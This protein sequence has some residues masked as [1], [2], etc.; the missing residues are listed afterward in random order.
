MFPEES[1]AMP[2]GPMDAYFAGISVIV[3]DKS[4]VP[5][6]VII[7]LAGKHPDPSKLK[8]P[9]VQ[10][11]HWVDKVELIGHVFMAGQGVHVVALG[12]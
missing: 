6:I 5:A 12:M 9:E 8:L 10:L 1:T 3:R 11:T 2:A 4:P 7:V